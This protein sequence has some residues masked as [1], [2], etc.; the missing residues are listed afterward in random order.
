MKTP[1]ALPP[2]WWRRVRH[3]LR[4]AVSPIGM[5]LRLLRDGR[6]DAAEREEAL[7]VIERQ[8]DSLLA[9]IDDVGEL[10]KLHS[11]EYALQPATQ[12]A[13]LLLDLVCGRGGL[14]RELATRA[15]GIRCEPCEHE[16]LVEHDPSRVSALLEFLLMRLAA[17]TDAGGELL[18]ALRRREGQ[19]ELELTG[20]K[21]ACAEDEELN[22]LL[23]GGD[24]D[25]S[26]RAMLMRELLR[27]SQLQMRRI[28]GGLALRFARASA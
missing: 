13:N 15:L 10:L 16:A 25:P 11:G 23:D 5:A 19:P 21:P 24:G 12:D 3:D 20:A 9:G 8:M 7:S 17:Y 1:P 22:Y 14:I 6:L 2:G 18:L 4:G 28:D 26:V 27:E